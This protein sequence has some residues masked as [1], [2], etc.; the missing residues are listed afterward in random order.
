MHQTN[1][2]SATKV[3]TKQNSIDVSSIQNPVQSKSFADNKTKKYWIK[4]DILSV[5]NNQQKSRDYAINQLNFWYNSQLVRWLHNWNFS[6][7]VWNL[8][9]QRQ[10]MKILCVVLI[11]ALTFITGHNST[12]SYRNHKVVSFK[13]ENEDQLKQLK[14]LETEPGVR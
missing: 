5:F 12:A 11:L 6:V 2:S 10:E 7:L 14:D 9:I 1:Q 3:S 13:I 8:L 4:S